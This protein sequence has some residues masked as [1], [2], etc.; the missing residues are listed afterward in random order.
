MANKLIN[1]KN[2]FKQLWEVAFQLPTDMVIDIYHS[3]SG[4]HHIKKSP[5]GHS[6]YDRPKGWDFTIKGTHRLSDHW[7]FE[8]NGKMHCVTSEPVPDNTHWTIAKYDEDLDTWI[9]YLIVEKQERTDEE[10]EE[11]K[12]FVFTH[13]KKVLAMVKEKELSKVDSE[14]TKLR[15][16][17]AKSIGGIEN[18]TNKDEHEKKFT[19]DMVNNKFKGLISH[20][21]KRRRNIE[22]SY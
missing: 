5:Y 8:S 12:T 15:N 3:M 14:L 19:I 21:E 18:S 10:F 13:R 1:K 17:L 16:T 7:N 6:Y 11:I 20:V 2:G 4:W 9:P 22:N